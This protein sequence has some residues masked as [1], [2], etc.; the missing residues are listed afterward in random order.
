MPSSPVS[1]T[2]MYYQIENIKFKFKYQW[3]TGKVNLEIDNWLVLI[4]L[5]SM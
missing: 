3:Q 2:I 5:V 1:N 4:Q